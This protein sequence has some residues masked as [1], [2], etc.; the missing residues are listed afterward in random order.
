MGKRSHSV[1]SSTA[2]FHH[3]I[4]EART[5]LITLCIMCVQYIRG[6]RGGR[7]VH[8]SADVMSTSGG[9]QYIRGIP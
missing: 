4:I 5:G 7:G 9:V 2:L 1:Q 3:K 6:G 8:T